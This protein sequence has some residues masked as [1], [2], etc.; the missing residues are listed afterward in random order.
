M[1]KVILCTTTSFGSS[2]PDALD[3][4]K[5]KG[6]IPVLN[7][8]KR[9]LTAE[10][11]GVLIAEHKPVGLLAGT[12][13]VPEE[14]L[15][16]AVAHLQ[17][18]SRVGVGWDNVDR[19]AA[20]RLGIKVFRTEGVLNDAVAELTLGLMLTVLRQLGLH[21][22]LMRSGKWE[23]HTGS[24]LKG[25]TVGIIGFGSIGQQVGKLCLAFGAR[26]LFSDPLS[27]SVDWAKAVTKDDL[28]TS[29]HIISIHADGNAALIGPA[30]VERCRPGVV[31]INTARGGMID[32]AALAK[33]IASGKIGGAGIDVFDNEPYAGELIESDKVV[34]TP[35][36]GSYAREARV[37]MES[38]AVDNLFSGLGI[39][40]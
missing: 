22:R 34:L 9:K 4:M 8:F 7:P 25:K 11:L 10:E 29:A 23:K 37:A 35:H 38:M 24:L 2:A 13:P 27:R 18:V 31:L 15:N 26:I 33:G 36:I 20:D 21:D 28:I 32:E 16:V 30:E 5:A 6:F 19:S 39:D 12:E 17:V 14:V 1:K 40:E 3:R